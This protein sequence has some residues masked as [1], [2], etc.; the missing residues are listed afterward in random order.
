MLRSAISA[1][2]SID[3]GIDDPLSRPTLTV[4]PPVPADYQAKKTSWGEPDFRG[5]WPID[6]LNGRT[7]L[8]SSSGASK[9]FAVNGYRHPAYLPF[10]RE[11]YATSKGTIVKN[12]VSTTPDHPLVGE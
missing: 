9:S 8:P 12:G 11:L 7:P 4:V 2:V 6:H 5:G 1:A 10:F 3:A